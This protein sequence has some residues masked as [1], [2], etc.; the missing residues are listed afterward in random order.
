MVHVLT[1]PNE[2][3]YRIIGFVDPGDL[4]HF[5]AS[6]PLLKCLA[7]D[8]LKVHQKRER[9]YTNVFIEGCHRE[10]YH[11]SSGMLCGLGNHPLHLLSEI[12][13][14]PEVA[15]YPTSL[16]VKC[17]G[18]REK[19]HYVEELVEDE[20]LERLLDKGKLVDTWKSDAVFVRKTLEDW[21]EEIQ[22]LVFDSGC[23]N[24]ADKERWYNRIRRGNRG[25]ALGLLLTLLP[26]LETMTFDKYTWN[27]WYF[28]QIVRYITQPWSVLS[29]GTHKE[30]AKVLTKLREVRLCGTNPTARGE[31]WD[32]C[33]DFDLVGHFAKLPSMRKVYARAANERSV[34]SY[35]PWI[36]VGTRTSNIDEII[37]DC[38]KVNATYV[39]ICLGSL[40]NLR[41]FH[42]DDSPLWDEDYTLDR[43]SMGIILGALLEHAKTSLE[44]LSL[45]AGQE[46]PLKGSTD[47]PFSLSPFE[48]LKKAS[49]SCHLYAPV[50]RRDEERY[51]FDGTKPLDGR[52]SDSRIQDSQLSQIPKLVDILPSSIEKVIFYGEVA[53][54]HVDAMLQGLVE[55][56]VDRLPHL[57]KIVFIDATVTAADKAVNIA[58]S[59]Q[60][61]CSGI[62]IRLLLGR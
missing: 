16:T 5:S 46:T 4:N 41:K 24:K 14:N 28:K 12:C 38:G 47:I 39:S 1:F 15:W 31:Y 50:F 57:E 43:S 18:Y 7:Q 55:R 59:L 54:K 58:I 3:L 34:V 30:G 53:M 19:E 23:F 36:K 22:D 52:G 40:K 42:Y 37:I 17:C 11:K 27:A 21:A 45:P 33:E 9:W 62:G 48:K 60:E 2:I 20:Y 10:S 6:C 32:I 29:P 8:A 13:K 35:N 25:A 56:R 49:L 61:Q 44:I 51:L 26:N